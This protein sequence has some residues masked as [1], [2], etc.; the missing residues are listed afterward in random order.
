MWPRGVGHPSLYLIIG[1][2][3]SL[4]QGCWALPPLCPWGQVLGS[5]SHCVAELSPLG[6]PG[7]DGQVGRLLRTFVHLEWGQEPGHPHPL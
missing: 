5:S 7:R 3:T 2:G 1:L 4:P 6:G